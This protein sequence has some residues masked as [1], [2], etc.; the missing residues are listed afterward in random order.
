MDDRA[1]LAPPLEV[2]GLDKPVAPG[3]V[4]QVYG[5]LESETV[6]V[7]ERTVVVNRSP[8]ATTFKLATSV[9]GLLLA[10]GLFLHQWRIDGRILAFRPR[11]ADPGTTDPDAE[12]NERG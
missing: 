3:G 8:S 1:E 12:V 5:P 6:L 9:V 4:V 7:A 10:V 2:R 11:A